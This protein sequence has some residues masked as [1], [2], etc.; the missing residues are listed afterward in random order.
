LLADLLLLL[1]EQRAHAGSRLGRR[2]CALEIANETLDLGEREADRLQLDDPVDAVDGLG[3]IQTEAALGA[4]ARLEQSELLVEVHRADGLVDRL[5]QLPD[6]H[7]LVGFVD[8]AP[9]VHRQT[10]TWT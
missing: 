6:A 2:A 3:P 1:V 10:L 8:G 9:V 5:R 7:Q 4:S